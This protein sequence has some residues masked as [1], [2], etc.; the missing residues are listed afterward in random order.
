MGMFYGHNQVKRE[1]L[2]GLGYGLLYNWYAGTDS[3]NIAPI[4]C[5]VPTDAEW[6]I[7]IT[8]LGGESVAG[9]KLKEVGLTH[10]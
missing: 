7:L 4:G 9:G 10:W 6:T 1:P 3:R 2:S 5:H 8:Y